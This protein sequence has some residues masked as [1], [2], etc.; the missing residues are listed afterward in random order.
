MKNAPVPLILGK[1][2]CYENASC[3]SQS[4]ALTVLHINTY[5]TS[6]NHFSEMMFHSYSHDVLA[7]HCNSAPVISEFIKCSPYN[8]QR[9][10]THLLG[11]MKSFS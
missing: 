5:G 10:F 7:I 3:V 11:P 6:R 2:I 1:L 8:V 9:F 4:A